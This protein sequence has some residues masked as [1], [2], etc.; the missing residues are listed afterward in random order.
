LI[1]IVILTILG[2]T[3]VKVPDGIFLYGS[4]SVPEGVL[5]LINVGGTESSLD[6]TENWVAM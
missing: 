4:K 2:D 6:N 1:R 5:A 3:T